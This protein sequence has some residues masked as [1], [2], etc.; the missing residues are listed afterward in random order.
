[1]EAIQDN[2]TFQSTQELLRNGIP[3]EQAMSN[4]IISKTMQESSEMAEQL[5]VAST[6]VGQRLNLEV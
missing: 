3:A 1:M 2:G 6:G 4:V 5:R